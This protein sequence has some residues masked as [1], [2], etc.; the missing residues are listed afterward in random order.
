MFVHFHDP[1]FHYFMLCRDL[2]P[3][4]LLMDRKTMVLKIADL[5]LARAFVIPIKKYTHEVHNLMFPHN[6]STDFERVT[7]S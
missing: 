7:H 6:I 4:N 2:K 5:G 1:H 3:H